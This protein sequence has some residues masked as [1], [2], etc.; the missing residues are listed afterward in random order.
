MSQRCFNV[1]SWSF[2]LLCF[3]LEFA[4]GCDAA[5]PWERHAHD[6]ADQHD[7]TAFRGNA[8]TSSIQPDVF[9]SVKNLNQRLREFITGWNKHKHPFVWTKTPEQVLAE[10]KPKRTSETR[11]SYV[12]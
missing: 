2:L 4:H 9:T 11:H 1:P 3:R 10:A 8:A 5:S 6:A 12:D 7:G